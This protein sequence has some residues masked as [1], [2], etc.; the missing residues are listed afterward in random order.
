MG[1]V[2][3]QFWTWRDVFQSRAILANSVVWVAFLGIYCKGLFIRSESL[4]EPIFT[5]GKRSLRRLCFYTCLS[6]CS[7]GEGGWYPSMH[8]RS[9]GPHPGGKLRGLAWGVSRP[10]PRGL[11]AYT[12]GVFRPTPGGVSR[13]TLGG[14]LGP[15]P[16][17]STH[18]PRGVSRHASGGVSRH[19]FEEG[20][21]PS[22]HWGRHP[23]ADIYC[24]GPILLECILVDSG[25]EEKHFM[26]DRDTKHCFDTIV[27][28]L[29]LDLTEIQI[30]M[31]HFNER[32]SRGNCRSPDWLWRS[33]N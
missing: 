13:P 5:A 15:H 19:T 3:R 26:A 11:Q 27:K 18:T 14:S 20:E 30:V 24:C 9:P 33:R 12:W 7:R 21:Y 6:F 2:V 23:P 8:C 1:P 28:I 32:V 29:H 10:T 22:M 31:H 17:V 16:G 4:W 25:Y